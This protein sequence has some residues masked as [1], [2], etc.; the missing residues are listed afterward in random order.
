M[1]KATMEILHYL[2]LAVDQDHPQAPFDYAELSL[3]TIDR[4]QNGTHRFLFRPRTETI[5][6]N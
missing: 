6:I 4:P 2:R 1:V 5:D 3:A